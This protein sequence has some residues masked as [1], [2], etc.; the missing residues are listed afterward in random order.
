M[1]HSNALGARQTHEHDAYVVVYDDMAM[2]NSNDL[3]IDTERKFL[4]Y[5]KKY[6]IYLDCV[7]P[8]WIVYVT[9]AERTL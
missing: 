9:S 3:C 7:V 8:Q 4:A 1:N 2:I 6:I 5:V